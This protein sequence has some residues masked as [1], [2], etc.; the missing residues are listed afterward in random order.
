MNNF[1]LPGDEVVSQINPDA[2]TEDLRKLLLDYSR[3]LSSK[4]IKPDALFSEVCHRIDEFPASS[5][6]CD[7]GREYAKKLSGFFGPEGMASIATYW[8][9]RDRVRAYQQANEI[10]SVVTRKV[11]IAGEEIEFKEVESQLEIIPGDT[12]ITKESIFPTTRSFCSLAQR[13]GYPIY[14]SPDDETF[15]PVDSEAVWLTA[16]KAWQAYIVQESIEW[17]PRRPDG[18]RSG[19][20][21]EKE[22]PDRIRIGFAIGE[23]ED[24]D[25]VFFEAERPEDLEDCKP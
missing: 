19:V 4:K 11:K 3:G 2:T 15:D 14:Y 25:W 6:E 20:F 23:P 21:V 7:E 16:N 22:I 24:D 9:V 8:L 10:S 18:S 1:Y 12:E 13:L 5:E 17:G